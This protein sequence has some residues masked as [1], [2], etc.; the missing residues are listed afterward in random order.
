MSRLTVPPVRSTP[1]LRDGVPRAALGAAV[2]VLAAIAI[3]VAATDQ[4]LGILALLCAV[5]VAAVAVGIRSWRWSIT[6]AVLYLPFAG[7]LPL[8]MFPN[9]GPGVLAKDVLLIVPAYIGC[10]VAVVTRRERLSVPGAPVLLFASLAALVVAGLFNP[11]LPDLLVGLIG[12]KV[13]LFTPPL[14]LLGYHLYKERG[15]LQR[16]LKVMLAL[17]MIPC[18]IGIIEAVLVAGG[19]SAFV[20]GLYGAAASAATQDFTVFQFGEGGLARLPSIFTS[21]SQYWL[22]TTATIAVGYA[23]WRGNRNDATM[24]WLGPLGIGVA[25]LASMTC[26]TRAAFIFSPIL[27]LLIALLEGVR[28][29]RLVGYTSVSAVAIV[30][31]VW[32]LGI[33]PWALARSQWSHAGFIAEFFGEGFSFGLQNALLG[34]GTGIDAAAARYAFDSDDPLVIYSLIGGV[35]YESWYLRAL[36]ELGVAGLVLLVLLIIA[37]TRRSLQH[38]R[39]LRDPELRSMSAAFIALYLWC[40]VYTFKTAYIDADPMAVYV[41]LFLGIQW[42]LLGMQRPA[43]AAAHAEARE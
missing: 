5:A 38:H 7:L 3:G 32:I 12:V 24:R 40:V 2:A 30:C 11:S 27:L 18:T 43:P 33:D 23:A 1:R 26:G 21:V 39:L 6:A 29:R 25:F 28:I 9:T 16:L 15:Q 8:A 20:Y 35:W 22:F 34:L 19:Q 4:R 10:L 17:A 41:W 37:V 14:L 36:L 31:A 42:S 13:W